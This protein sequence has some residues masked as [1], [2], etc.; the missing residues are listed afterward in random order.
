[1]FKAAT[2]KFKEE[3]SRK[4]GEKMGLALIEKLGQN[5]GAC[6]LFCEP[7]AH[8]SDMINGII[9]VIET[10][11]LVGCTGGA[12]ISTLGFSTKSVV[13]GGIVSD[14]IEFEIASVKHIGKNSEAAG[15][16]LG[17]LFSS[18]VG[19]IQIFS[20]GITGNG[21]G[22]LRGIHSGIQK[23]IPITGGTAGDAGH[24]IQSLQFAGR[25]IFS[26]A[27]VAIGFKGQFSVGTGVQSGWA[28]IGLPKKVTRSSENILYELNGEPALNVFRRF[29]GKHAEKLPA[30]GVEYPLGF[31]TK[32]DNDEYFVLRTT[33]AVNPKEGSIT[34]A[35]E[36]P[37]ETMV[38]L[39]CGDKINLLNA[40]EKAAQIAIDQLEKNTPVMAFCCSCIARK[41]LL[42]QRT[43]EEFNRVN[44]KLGG[45]PI[46]GFYTF[47]EFCRVKPG[48]PSLFHNESIAITVIGI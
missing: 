22:L 44:M 11:A 35:G 38:H 46:L 15:K 20:D 7:G 31:Y 25:E 18:S 36:L 42:G 10:S 26:D 21:C 12:E 24:F 27:A 8:L 47:G 40:T 39:T 30:V 13:L 33:M 17:R 6:W 1:M 29:L 3:Y 9:D 16:K 19:F 23:N 5:P 34:F 32:E 45:I 37:E 48:G 41:T 14:Q 2:V 43:K 4:L 28:P